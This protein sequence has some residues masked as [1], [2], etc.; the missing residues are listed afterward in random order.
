MKFNYIKITDNNYICRCFS[1]DFGY[2]GLC[3]AI[4]RIKYGI[5]INKI[6]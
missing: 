1:E 5:E 2:L 4:K 3:K 6:K